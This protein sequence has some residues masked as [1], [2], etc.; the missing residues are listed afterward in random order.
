MPGRYVL[1]IQYIP[2]SGDGGRGKIAVRYWSKRKNN[3]YAPYCQKLAVV[4]VH[5][6]TARY[7]ANYYLPT[8]DQYRCGNC[9]G[10]VWV[11]S[12][13]AESSLLRRSSIIPEEEGEP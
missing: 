9:G 8:R 11:R 6:L 12:I 5:K 3:P 2:D 7:L 10:W 4:P 1:S 13:T